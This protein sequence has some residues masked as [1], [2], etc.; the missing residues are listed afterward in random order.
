VD[1][2]QLTAV[3]R[4]IEMKRRVKLEKIF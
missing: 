1:D 3:A 2:V 4:E